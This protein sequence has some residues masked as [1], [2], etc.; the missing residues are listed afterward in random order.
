MSP[1]SFRMTELEGAVE[2]I[3]ITISHTENIIW[4]N[5]PFTPFKAF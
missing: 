3:L 2:D 4:F 5:K 1:G